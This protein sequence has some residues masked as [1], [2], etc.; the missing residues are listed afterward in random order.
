MHSSQETPAPD[1]AFVFDFQQYDDPDGASQRWSTW[2]DADPSNR[3]PE[4][5]PDW[6]I[7]DRAAI[8]TEQLGVLKTGK[9]ADVFL[10]ERALADGPSRQ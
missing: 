2:W 4:P 8:D 6:V 5:R 7:T 1:P 10:L 9:E 3:G